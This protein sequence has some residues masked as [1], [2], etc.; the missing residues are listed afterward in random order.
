[1]KDARQAI[2]KLAV[3]SAGFLLLAGGS[4]E[5]VPFAQYILMLSVLAVAAPGVP[6]GMVLAAAPRSRE[7]SRKS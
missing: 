3:F 1:M 4:I 7:S 5:A 2:G 6:G